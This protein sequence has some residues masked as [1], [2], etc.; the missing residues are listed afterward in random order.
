MSAPL[1]IDFGNMMD[2]AIGEHGLTQQMLDETA[3]AI[4]QAVADLQMA[5]S[6]GEIPFLDLPYQKEALQEIPRLREEFWKNLYVPDGAK[7]LN[8]NLEV[9]GRVADYLELSELM[10]R[11]A[12]ER[13]ESCGGHF[14]EEHQTP[15][16]EALR[17]DDELSFVS[18]WEYAGADQSP[19]LHKEQLTFEA[20][21]LAQRSYQ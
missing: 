19:K 17:R 21:H 15:E 13:G 16:G 3:P 6:K 8:K 1:K 18:A 12:L 2:T 9:A 5:R 7:S 10:A 4:A 20:V 11:D 14:R